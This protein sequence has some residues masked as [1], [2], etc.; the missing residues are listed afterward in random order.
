M[1]LREI[2][3]MPTTNFA[4]VHEAEQYHIQFPVI[5]NRVEISYFAEGSLDIR[6]GGE[7]FR[8][9]KGDILC[10][11]FSAPVSI[12]TA[13]YHCHHTVS[14][15]L[16][17]EYTQNPNGLCL[18]LLLPASK[19]TA[20]I[21]ELIDE[22][23]FDPYFS[24]S[25][26]TRDAVRILNI[27]CKIDSVYRKWADFREST[28]SALAVRAMR[29]IHR[30][31]RRPITQHEVARHLGVSEGYLCSVFKR[32][33]GIT[34]IRYVN[35]VKLKGVQNLME[36]NRMKLYEAAA[37]FGYSDPNYVSALYKRIFGRNITAMPRHPENLE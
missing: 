7:S 2:L 27:L 1:E 24:L 20:A 32:T 35:M 10:N 37:E 15:T 6:G 22:C 3:S 21:T 23:I 36:K 14:A 18:P 33:Q 29:Y 9:G 30:N 16:Q 4:H 19:D 13:E 26:S 11:F 28:G 12:E 31:I 8:A 25:V 5:E 34:L 17:W